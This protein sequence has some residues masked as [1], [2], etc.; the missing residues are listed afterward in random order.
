MG[1]LQRTSVWLLFLAC[2]DGGPLIAPGSSSMILKLGTVCI[3]CGETPDECDVHIPSCNI[4]NHYIVEKIAAWAFELHDELAEFTMENTNLRYVDDAAFCGTNISTLTLRKSYLSEVPNVICINEILMHLDLS[5]NVIRNNSSSSLA[6]LAVLETLN[7]S[8]NGLEY[9][10]YNSLCGTKLTSLNLNKN[11]LTSTLNF[12]CLDEM[13]TVDML[14]NDIQTIP[15]D[16]FKNVKVAIQLRL[17]YNSLD[18]VSVLVE[19]AKTTGHLYLTGNNLTCF[20]VVSLC[21]SNSH[22]K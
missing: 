6:Y 14:E 12:S 1:L 7:I 22:W 17:E 20:N 9:A 21:L 2:A 11:R 18:N 13:S 19:L 10:E 8:N 4:V 16:S 3:F 5:D 15:D